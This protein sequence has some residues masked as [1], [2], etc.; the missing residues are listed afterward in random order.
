MSSFAAHR[1][2]GQR[3]IRGTRPLA[4]A[5]RKKKEGEDATIGGDDLSGPRP[6]SAVDGVYSELPISIIQG[7]DA[8]QAMP[9]TIRTTPNS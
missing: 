8:Q 1:Q 2:V 7:D 6:R 5:P 3:R 4:A 9:R